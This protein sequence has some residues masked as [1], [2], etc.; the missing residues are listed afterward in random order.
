MSSFPWKLAAAAAVLVCAVSVVTAGVW[1]L[2]TPPPVALPTVPAA[3]PAPDAKKPAEPERVADAR[4]RARSR[5]NLKEIV[6][7]MISYM[8]ANDHLPQNITDKDGKPLLSWRVEVLP[9]LGAEELYKEFKRDEPWDSEHN[10]KLLAKMP[11]VFRVGFEAKGETKTY[12]QGFVGTG[13]LFE[14]GK[15]YKLLDITD[16]T[17]NTIAIVEA[18]P[19]VEWTRPADI[20]YDPK[21]PLPELEGPFSNTLL[22]A[23]ADG[24][25][26]PFPRD[27][28]NASLRR[29]IEVADGEAVSPEEL[30]GKF[31]LTVEDLKV[32]HEVMVENE[33]LI[34][35]IG[36]QIKEQQKLILEL[37]KRSTVKGA[38]IEGVD[39]EQLGKMTSELRIS[40]TQL[41]R[42]TEDLKKQLE[43]APPAPKK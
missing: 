2:T 37:V 33:K 5:N 31:P 39:L 42:E 40:L 28:D 21:K 35:D 14:P 4:Q 26:H 8:D 9:F 15:Q 19:P 38:T 23:T 10:K 29:M 30:H 17:A 27:L 34:R 18:G 25:T 24:G 22:A 13:T 32:A 6:I 43:A 3:A 1:G 12:Y 20:P 36:A 7:A 16:G 41:Q 11:N